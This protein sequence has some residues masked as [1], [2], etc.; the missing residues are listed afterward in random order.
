LGIFYQ[1]FIWTFL[2]LSKSSE[3]TLFAAYAYS[4]PPSRNNHHNRT[5]KAPY[6]RMQQ[7]V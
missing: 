5:G 6:P 4:K 1:M 3:G 2:Q 7:H